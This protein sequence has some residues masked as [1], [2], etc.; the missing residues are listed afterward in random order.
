MSSNY[1]TIIHVVFIIQL[2]L[3]QTNLNLLIF[4]LCNINI[5]MPQ[6]S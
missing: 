6:A 2:F 3:F 5:G 1:K 4:S